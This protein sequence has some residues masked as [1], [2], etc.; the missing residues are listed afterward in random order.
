MPNGKDL[1]S[2]A[3][4]VIDELH[5]EQPEILNRWEVE[6]HQQKRAHFNDVTSE[7][8]QLHCLPPVAKTNDV[9]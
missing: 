2:F 3:S 5:L 6:Y 1:T 9:R 7:D 8:R 4:G